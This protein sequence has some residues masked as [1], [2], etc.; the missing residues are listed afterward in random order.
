MRLLH[1]GRRGIP[2]RPPFSGGDAARRR[3]DRAVKPVLAVAKGGGGTPR[4][5]RRDLATAW[6]RGKRLLRTSVAA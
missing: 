4:R 2:A 5:A 6:F 1:L 3:T